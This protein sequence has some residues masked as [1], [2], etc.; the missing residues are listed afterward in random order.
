M[1]ITRLEAADNTFKETPDTYRAITNGLFVYPG[2]SISYI[3]RSVCKILSSLSLFLEDCTRLIVYPLL[4]SRVWSI[5][6]SRNHTDGVLTPM[7]MERGNW[8]TRTNVFLDIEM[9]VIY[10]SY[11]T[12]RQ[13][14][15]HRRSDIEYSGSNI[16]ITKQ[17]HCRT[18][19]II[20]V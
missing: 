5:R 8:W 1:D 14:V 10:E 19:F 9:S 17:I 16:Y 18:I 6:E 2:A 15:N 20:Y 13:A 7:R 3:L 12:H 4:L 11:Q